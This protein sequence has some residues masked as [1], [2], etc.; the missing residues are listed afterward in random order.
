MNRSLGL[1]MATI[2]FP[3][4][5]A[6]TMGAALTGGMVKT[7]LRYARV[8]AVSTLDFSPE[9]SSCNRSPTVTFL[10]TIKF[11]RALGKEMIRRSSSTAMLRRAQDLSDEM[12]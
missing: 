11:R 12:L 1:L 6:V 7:M 4:S 8:V 3:L 9:T 10:I 2:A 5:A